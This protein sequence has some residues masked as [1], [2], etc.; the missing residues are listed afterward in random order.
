MDSLKT[1]GVGARR[2][3]R[4]RSGGGLGRSGTRRGAYWQ[5]RDAQVCDEW[6]VAMEYNNRA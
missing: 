4:E 5:D 1:D 6:V 2:S 3:R